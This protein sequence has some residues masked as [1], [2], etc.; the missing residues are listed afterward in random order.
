MY[1]P[2]FGAS[3]R[4]PAGEAVE[5]HRINT[6]MAA[7]RKRKWGTNSTVTQLRENIRVAN[8][9]DICHEIGDRFLV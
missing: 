5:R 2:G 6:A 8:E 1:Q 9:M 3:A 7:R 4:S